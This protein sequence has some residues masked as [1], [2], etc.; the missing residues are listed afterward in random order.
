MVVPFFAAS[1]GASGAVA[2]GVVAVDWG[3]GSVA[4]R[5]LAVSISFAVPVALTITLSVSFAVS[6]TVSVSIPTVPVSIPIST[7]GF[8]ISFSLFTTAGTVF[9]GSMAATQGL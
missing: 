4:T 7:S 9:S 3:G 8:A 2:G 1:F 5:A 6:A